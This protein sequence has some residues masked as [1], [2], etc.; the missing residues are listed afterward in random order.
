MFPAPFFTNPWISTDIPSADKAA[1]VTVLTNPAPLG[2]QT[3]YK[4]YIYNVYLYIYSYIHISNIF[5]A[6]YAFNAGGSVRN[7]WGLYAAVR[8]LK[9]EPRIRFSKKQQQQHPRHKKV[10][11][12][13]SSLA[14]RPLHFKKS[15]VFR[16][17]SDHTQ[18]CI[19]SSTRFN[20][21]HQDFCYFCQAIVTGV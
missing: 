18:I 1:I 2:I 11:H 21:L 3:F 5:V 6:V 7:T 14:D 17:P 9:T 12:S 8:S 13:L 16:S 20:S 15:T 10:H 19:S 4:M